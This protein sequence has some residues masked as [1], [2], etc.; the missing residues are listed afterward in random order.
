MAAQLC[1][2]VYTCVLYTWVCLLV[3]GNERCVLSPAVSPCHVLQP[4]RSAQWL[5]L[6]TLMWWH[7]VKPQQVREKKWVRVCRVG[8][9]GGCRGSAAD[10]RESLHGWKRE[11]QRLKNDRKVWCHSGGCHRRHTGELTAFISPAGPH[12]YF[13]PL[14]FTFCMFH[15]HMFLIGPKRRGRKRWNMGRGALLGSVW[16]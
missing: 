13:P 15:P 1:I 9:G 8:G 7:G 2:S 14:S 4:V 10:Q 5:E 12:L 6:P 11:K 16:V 3:K